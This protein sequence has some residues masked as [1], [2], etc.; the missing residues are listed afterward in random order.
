MT[1]RKARGI[2]RMNTRIVNGLLEQVELSPAAFSI[3]DVVDGVRNVETIC[4]LAENAGI[5][6]VETK[7]ILEML[8]SKGILVEKEG[9][10][11]EDEQIFSLYRRGGSRDFLRMDISPRIHLVQEDLCVQ[12]IT[13]LP[14][15]KKGDIGDIGEITH[16]LQKILEHASKTPVIEFVEADTYLDSSQMVE[17]VKTA[18]KE[19]EHDMPYFIFEL[20]QPTFNAEEMN[21]LTELRAP[22]TQCL[23]SMTVIGRVF[24][25]SALTVK[26]GYKL[27]SE[28][29]YISVALRADKATLEDVNFFRKFPQITLFF[30]ADIDDITTE[31]LPRFVY[32]ILLKNAR[33]L[34]REGLR[35]VLQSNYLF[36]WEDDMYRVQRAMQ[37]SYLP[38]TDCGAGKRKI[39]VTLDGNVYPCADAARKGVLLGN[40][41][42]EPLDAI[43]N[44]EKA[45]TLRENI[46]N[47]FEKC[48]KEC[49]LAYF[50][51]GCIIEEKC[52]K[53]KEMLSLFLEKN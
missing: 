39:A 12:R 45:L 20:T 48:G 40:L 42:R 19:L 34:N 50:C 47:T 3:F 2:M 18:V 33:A 43:L 16:L 49:C 41:T 46:K 7:K 27:A 36:F 30:V 14:S 15:D 37:K 5:P 9:V 17:L 26:G 21:Q 13:F 4:D 8:H 11:P 44:G 31:T 35:T 22:H 32:P 38:L 53:K 24:G 10:Y 51:S 25:E 6:R 29:E 28:D 1:L 23:T 52:N